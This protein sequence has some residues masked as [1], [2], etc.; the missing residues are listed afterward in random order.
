MSKKDFILK[1]LLEKG[2]LVEPAV[3]SYIE[4][5][6]G[7]NYLPHFIEKYRALGYVTYSNLE[8]N[9]S[10]IKPKKYH[11]SQKNIEKDAFNHPT[12]S[13]YDWDFKVIM[14]ASINMATSGNAEDFK[15]LFEDRYNRIYP[16]LSTRVALRNQKKINRLEDEYASVIGL[17]SDVKHTRN[18]SLMFDIEDP[19]GVIRC[20]AQDIDFILNDEIIGV[21]GKYSKSRKLFYVKKIVRPGAAEIPRKRKIAEPIGAAIISDIH[22][23]S[24]TFIKKRWEKFIKWLKSGKNGSEIVKY[25]LIAGDVVDGIGVYPH[26][27]EELEILD[28]FE[29]YMALAQSLNDVPDYIKIVMIPGNHDIVRNAEPQ[30]A[31]P[32]EI[33]K[34]FNGNVEF[35]SNPTEFSIHG[36]KF[37]M[38]HGASLNNLVELIPGMDYF[39]TGEIMKYMIDMRHLSPVYGE[40]V[41]IVPTPKDFLVIDNVP[42]V[43]IT[44]HVHI[45]SYDRYHGIHL[46]N[47]SAWQEQTKYQK[48][49]NFNPDPGKVAILNFQTDS[50]TVK[51][52]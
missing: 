48:M 28:V 29:Q 40:K 30:P 50:V 32:S 16:F 2:I 12:A 4:E 10:E 5:K 34:M 14:D 22:I 7:A 37:L 27:E 20:L 46:I 33:Q 24:N 42:D 9:D 49:M 17:V 25:L 36:Y 31:L 26:Q 3:V 39:K 21:I 38:Y 13:E 6:G 15:R 1:E 44:G 41:P 47:A 11:T 23:G 19:T 35:L 52:F 45:F 51:V 18:G 43:L 8:N